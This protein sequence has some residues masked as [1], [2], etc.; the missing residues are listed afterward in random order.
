[1][2]KVLLTEDDK[3]LLSLLLTDATRKEIAAHI[4]KHPRSVEQRRG[5]IQ[6]KLRVYGL[7]Q[8]GYVA[9][10]MGFEPDACLKLSRDVARGPEQHAG[11][12]RKVLPKGAGRSV[13]RDL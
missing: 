10:K 6:S 2:T 11:K 3:S 12:N 4:G 9:A 1:M 5:S 13:G 7:V 8:L